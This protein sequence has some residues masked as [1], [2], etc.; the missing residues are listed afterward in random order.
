MK[1]HKY[2]SH[3]LVK[4][5]LIV[6]EVLKNLS[7]DPFLSPHIGLMLPNVTQNDEEDGFR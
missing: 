6:V 2:H 3:D 5:V 7:C 1:K 4:P